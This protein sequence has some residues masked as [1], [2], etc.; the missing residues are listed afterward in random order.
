MTNDEFGIERERVTSEIRFKKDIPAA[1]LFI[2]HSSF[3]IRH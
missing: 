2:R 3:V 1:T